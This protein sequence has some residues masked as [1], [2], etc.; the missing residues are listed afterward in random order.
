MQRDTGLPESLREVHHALQPYIKQRQEALRVRQVLGAH[1]STHVQ[2]KDA[3]PIF[4]PLS[5]LE[6]SPGSETSLKG[7]RG[8]QREYIQCLASNIKARK[9]FAKASREHQQKSTHSH[10]SGD[11][12]RGTPYAQGDSESALATFIDTVKCRRKHERLCILQDYVD[13]VAE[14]LPETTGQLGSD[15][16]LQTVGSLP[17]IPPEVMG[18]ADV[19]RGP[20]GPDLKGLVDQLEKAVLRARLLLQREQKY[21]EKVKCRNNASADLPSHDGAKLQALGTTRNELIQW[22]ETELANTADDSPDSEDTIQVDTAENNDGDFIDSEL[23]SIQRQ[24]NQYSKYRRAL[25]IAATG[26]LE[27][28]SPT[29]VSQDLDSIE[30]TGAPHNSESINHVMYPYLSEMMSLSSEQKALIQQKSHFTISLAKHLKEAGQGVDRLAEESHLLPAHPMPRTA[31]HGS[32]FDAMP[33]FG[34]SISNQEKPDSSRKAQAWVFAADRARAATKD[35]VAG[36]IEESR[37]DILGAQRTLLE[38]QRLLGEDGSVGARTAAK[39]AKS[40]DI[41]ASLDG[42]LGAIK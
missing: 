26:H 3:Y 14:K 22:I 25:I 31:S 36:K 24:Y 28:P 1:L 17:Q 42:N 8:V 30:G 7:V 5:L 19:H 18:T 9:E 6:A 2:Q 40:R 41:W 16:A 23:V 37:M 33:T 35:S 34:G 4:H 38:L 21:L 27:Q 39:Q 20:D 13:V 32:N 10:P 12:A 15:V 29:K 11:S